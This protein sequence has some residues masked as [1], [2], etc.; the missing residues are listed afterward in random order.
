[1]AGN[2]KKAE[3]SI[4]ADIDALAPGGNPNVQMYKDMFANMSDK[5]FD[6]FMVGLE[7]GTNILAFVT[8]NLEKKFRLSVKRNFAL[9]KLW[10]HEFFE[11]IWLTS[12]DD[13]P[14]YLSNEKYLL[15]DWQLRRQAQL[16]T[17]KVSIPEG[18]SVD[19]F[20]GQPTGKSK[21]SKISFPELGV[22]AS[23]KLDYSI[24]EMLKA[25]GGDEKSMNAMNK[26]IHQ[27]GGASQAA[28]EPY[29]GTVKSTEV[30][31]AYLTAM[32]LRNTLLK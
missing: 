10:G 11:R 31:Y 21:G 22:L 1:M 15:I 2:R 17:K 32:H 14:P 29:G 13:R 4:L 8:P 30:L 25:R 24:T 9:A 20:S 12:G 19:D 18:R 27:T 6:T 7:D 5:E 23:M 28:M 16:L 26:F 3:A